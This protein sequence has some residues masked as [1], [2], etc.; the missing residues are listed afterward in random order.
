MHKIN[1]HLYM[2]RTHEVRICS[3]IYLGE[4]EGVF[5]SPETTIFLTTHKIMYRYANECGVIYNRP[6]PSLYRE[7]SA[8]PPCISV[9]FLSGFWGQHSFILFRLFFV[10][11]CFIGRYHNHSS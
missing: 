8:Q 2:I 11:V 9:P 1:G 4:T 10:R 5:S 3:N 6:P 7:L